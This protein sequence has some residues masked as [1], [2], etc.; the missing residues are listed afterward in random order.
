MLES[1]PCST[2]CVVSSFLV[3]HCIHTSPQVFSVSSL[4]MASVIATQQNWF[5]PCW[6][7]Y[8]KSPDCKRSQVTC[9]G[10]YV[11]GL[12]HN[13][14]SGCEPGLLSSTTIFLLELHFLSAWQLLAVSFICI[15]SRGAI[16]NYTHFLFSLFF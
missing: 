10:L 1:F 12:S 16:L 8:Q 3:T 2:Y 7:S 11:A 15:G 14:R 13:P 4:L 6:D 9:L 5:P